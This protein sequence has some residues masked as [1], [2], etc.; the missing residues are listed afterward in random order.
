MAGPVNGDPAGLLRRRLHTALLIVA[1][2]L[3][4]LSMLSGCTKHTDSDAKAGV[5]DTDSK[6]V[7]ADGS[8][9]EEEDGG[10][11]GPPVTD[12][13]LP[14][15]VPFTVKPPAGAKSTAPFSLVV[16]GPL[17]V[18]VEPTAGGQNYYRLGMKVQ[19]RPGRAPSEL[20]LAA[21]SVYPSAAPDAED[22]RKAHADQAGAAGTA[23]EARAAI[24]L[25]CKG[26]T[27]LDA[28]ARTAGSTPRADGSW[29]LDGTSM[30]P[31]T[32]CLTFRYQGT[33]TGFAYQTSDH[34]TEGKAS[35]W[36][37]LVLPSAQLKTAPRILGRF[38]GS[39][40]RTLRLSPAAV[41]G[42]GKVCWSMTGT[43]YNEVAGVSAPS[44]GSPDA[45]G[46]AMG[47]TGGCK[48]LTALPPFLQV[49]GSRNG[50]W[51]IIVT[52]F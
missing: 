29:Y 47:A 19:V 28:A 38:D 36:W 4:A 5:K 34:G 50:D 32:G 23:L 51:S 27:P 17:A 35:A 11:Q 44:G 22:G 9:R 24:S 45:I 1:A 41:S 2:V 40:N 12:G 13:L 25:A 46:A 26:V 6:A 8:S 48:E 15:D 14:L 10:D 39:G 21:F 42:A 16:L 3:A 52:D 49:T 33:P 30:K 31:F 20:Q 37:P 18:A 43:Q 7:V